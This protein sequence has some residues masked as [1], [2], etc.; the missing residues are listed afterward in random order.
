MVLVDGLITILL[1][2]ANPDTSGQVN[3]CKLG[4]KILSI[5]EVSFTSLE[6]L[7]GEELLLLIIHC[8]VTNKKLDML[9]CL[10]F[11]KFKKGEKIVWTVISQP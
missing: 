2:G 6:L 9:T 5:I 10:S 7:I 4:K 1:L 3:G 8:I 11:V